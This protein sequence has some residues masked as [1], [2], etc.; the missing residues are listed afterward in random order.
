MN[1]FNASRYTCVGLITGLLIILFSQPA[2]ADWA[3][4]ETDYGDP[5]LFPSQ[6]QNNFF[7]LVLAP[8]I[9]GES[10]P[11]A[12]LHVNL[13]T[14]QTMWTIG[15]GKRTSEWR[16]C[17]AYSMDFEKTY[18]L[19]MRS[20]WGDPNRG[21]GSMFLLGIGFD[22]SGYGSDYS[23]ERHDTYALSL[24]T[25]YSMVIKPTKELSFEFFLGF[26]A[27]V[28]D[29]LEDGD[30]GWEDVALSFVP[31]FKM[32]YEVVTGGHPIVELRFPLT[33]MQPE[34]GQSDDGIYGSMFNMD[35]AIGYRQSWGPLTGSFHFIIGL[36]GDDNEYLRDRDEFGMVFDFGFVFY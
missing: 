13:Q 24:S 23:N 9:D 8:V 32:S 34:S 16:H 28:L 20:M 10:G 12:G 33:V 36:L 7:Q 15:M 27:F 17:Y 6:R 5:V 29:M 3:A 1:S 4:A 26:N 2:T 31:A 25:G 22:W 30:N 35:M 18:T 19:E 21:V 14:G 11:L